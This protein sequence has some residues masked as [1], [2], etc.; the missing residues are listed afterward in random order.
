MKIK[1]IT[2]A[3]TMLLLTS[4]GRLLSAQELTTMGT[5]FW[6][7]PN[8]SLCMRLELCDIQ[9]IDLAFLLVGPRNCTAYISN[10]HTDFDTSLSITPGAVSY[11]KIYDLHLPA[12]T[13]TLATCG[14]HITSTDSISVYAYAI[15]FSSDA[16][17]VL[18]THALKSDYIIQTYPSPSESQVPN[19]DHSNPSSNFTIVATEDST[20]VTIL[21]NGATIAGDTTG[22]V[23]S[24]FIPQAG[25]CRQVVST[26]NSDLSG[27]RVTASGGKRIAVFQGNDRP[28]NIGTTNIPPHLYEQAIPTAYWGRHFFAH[29]NSPDS[30]IVR[31]TS[32][33]NNCL[34]SVN[35][36]YVTTIGERETYEYTISGNRMMDYINT[37]QP[38]CV[39]LYTTQLDWQHHIFPEM[40]IVPPFEQASEGVVFGIS[41]PI[42]NLLPTSLAEQIHIITKSNEIQFIQLDSNDISNH[43][44]PIDVNPA[45]SYARFIVDSGAHTLYT[46]DGNGFVAWIHDTNYIWFSSLY[47]VGTALRDAQ[48]SLTIG[49]TTHACWIDTVEI[50][51]NNDITMSVES[52]YGFD[53]VQWLLGDG[54]NATSGQIT[55]SFTQTGRYGVRAIVFASCDGCY[56]QIDTLTSTIA[57]FDPDTTYADT[58]ICSNTFIW[59]DS[60]YHEGDRI[61]TMYQNRHGCDSLII[62][63]LH[64]R[65]PSY[66]VLDTLYA[67]DSL[68]FYG[69]WYTQNGLVSHDTLTNAA[70]C[71]SA[72]CYYVVIN[73]QRSYSVADTIYGCDS[74]LLDNI[75]YFQDTSLA[76]DTL[77]AA[78]S[79]DSILF[80]AIAIND[81]YYSTQNINIRDT[82][83]LVW[84]DG[85][86]YTESTDEP[87]VVLQ[88]HN[89][90]DSTVHLH[91]TVLPTPRPQPLDSTAIWV[92][93]VFTPDEDINSQFKIFCN[94]IISAEV[95]VF[96]RWGLHICTFDGLTE[97]WDGTMKGT[98]CPQGT[99]VYIIEY[100]SRTRP[101]Y[102]QRK[103][104]TVT[105]VR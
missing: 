48:N 52:L 75:W 70:G 72:L 19:N 79:C 34:I 38:S 17:N 84:I 27:T 36:H 22:D 14:F 15:H 87:F 62:S 45:F 9:I 31:I 91:L 67:C 24:V 85:N 2:F 21:L 105:L 97:S 63:T 35:N 61:T 43:F 12:S 30:N 47:S 5:D 46:T 101:Q 69:T 41:R 3:I 13:D 8:Y 11:V 73:T 68:L 90:C 89:G 53:S 92:P 23:L 25:L 55:H 74:L 51:I 102:T 26:L 18:P 83:E 65:D 104:G 78:N 59:Q 32:L 20:Y 96:N 29:N 76:F 82:A 39:G 28:Y 16:T 81:S 50:C 42:Q 64:F 66:S 4:G 99:Y 7:A 40:L 77:T 80:H 33:A 58:T 103:I 93:N 94:D 49:N 98:A 56:R 37:S 54:Y 95:S 1:S 57:V 6:V 100:T 88:A 86:T 60:T 71:D 44:S 10:P